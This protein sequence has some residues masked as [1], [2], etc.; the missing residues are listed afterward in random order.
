M[1]QKQI[2][3]F[4]IVGILLFIIST[5]KLTA[6]EFQ[7]TVVGQII[8][9]IDKT[10]VPDVHVFFKNA[11]NGVKS[12]AEGYF[13]VRS[14]DKE[15]KVIV[16][17][18]IGYNTKEIRIKPGQSVGMRVEMTEQNTMLQDVIVISG[19]NPA[20]DLMKK[21]RNMKAV[22]DITQYPDF[23]LKRIEQGAVFLSKVNQRNINKRIYSAIAESML[24]RSDSSLILPLYI[25]ENTYQQ[26]GKEKTL[27]NSDS[28]SSEE[29]PVVLVKKLFGD[30]QA[31]V[32]FY[33][34]SLLFLDKYL[35]SPLSS[36]GTLFYNY[37]LIDSIKTETDKI[38]K[39]NFY[40]KNSKNLAFNG[41]MEID[42]ASC[43]LVSIKASL[44][45]RANVNYIK[46]LD[47][48]QFFSKQDNNM[49][50]PEKERIS[51]KLTYEILADSLNQKPELFISNSTAFSADDKLPERDFNFGGTE[52]T[53][54]E[55]DERLAMLNDTRLLRTAKWIADVVITGYIPVWK[56]D[57][58]KIEEI[59]RIT[60]VEGFKLNI[61]LRTN[62]KM[63]R[64][65][66]VGGHA[67]YGFGNQK[68]N[69]SVY[70]QAKLNKKKNTVLEISYGDEYHRIDY[71]YNDFMVRENPLVTGDADIANTIFGFRAGTRLN[72]RKEFSATLSTDINSDIETKLIFRSNTLLPSNWLPLTKNGSNLS[73]FS[74][75]SLVL[76]G[77][78]SFGER[79]YEDHF[80]R[81]YIRNYE[82]IIYPM[83]QVGRYQAGN[84][85]GNYAKIS[86]TIKQDVNFD[87]GKW[88]YIIQG[89]LTFGKV[90]Y[91]L[92]D[93]IPGSESYGYGYNKFSLMY[94]MEY[95]S[96]KYILMHNELTTN[97]ILF[98]QIPLIQNLNLREMASFKI[99]YGGLKNSHS[100]I[101]DYPEFMH[102]LNE[103]YMEVG[104]G[105]ANILK[106]LNIQSIWRLTD[107]SRPETTRWGI[108]A[109]LRITF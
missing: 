32:N 8:N 26:K 5:L 46:S 39:V 12:D 49:W 1:I 68:L 67:G 48:Q 52:Y 50:I 54:S 47:I 78:F 91:P 80:Q 65:F 35:I 53:Q 14:Y 31:N 79:T 90:P 105:V 58:G 100:E 24:S 22:N 43:A 34:N 40:T 95:A 44:S 20:L 30:V 94:S 27:L 71:N 81:I 70:G 88:I 66:C 11:S 23:S 99:L 45:P 25:S 101:L 9:S 69:Y 84:I 42:S 62:E 103:P 59:M 87:F 57:I 97:G 61:P 28:F 74:Y 10:P 56:F 77:R 96:D 85:S 93:I 41:T 6:Q 2:K 109:S 75:Q 64:N 37:F 16:F 92:L 60:D 29:K 86:G 104:V 83:I 3:Y 7:T 18:C 13:M 108:L 4:F 73:S 89:G 19:A 51:M 21:V 76:T 38:Y 106:I 15:A 98:N 17:S 107:T 55:L 102:P 33:D 82:P 36:S 63:M 72:E